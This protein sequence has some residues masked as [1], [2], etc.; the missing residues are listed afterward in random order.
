MLQILMSLPETTRGG[1]SQVTWSE[2]QL[3]IPV[4]CLATLGYK[5]RHLANKSTVVPIWQHKN[6]FAVHYRC[7]PAFMS[8]TTSPNLPRLAVVFLKNSLQ[9]IESDTNQLLEQLSLT[10]DPAT[11]RKRKVRSRTDSQICK[12]TR[13]FPQR[14]SQSFIFL[15]KIIFLINLPMKHKNNN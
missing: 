3:K 12:A 13:S 11:G 4:G 7:N 1:S 2:K 10:S 8:W 6:D 15:L 14:G 9:R 5:A